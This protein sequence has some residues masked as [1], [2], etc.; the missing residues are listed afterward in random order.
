MIQQTTS[1]YISK[2]KEIIILK[3]Y[4]YSRYCSIIKSSQDT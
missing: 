4:L 3:K 2:E 1:G